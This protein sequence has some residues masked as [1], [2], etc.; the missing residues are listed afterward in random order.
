MALLEPLQEGEALTAAASKALEELV[1]KGR[2]LLQAKL[3][4]LPPLP[5]S[6]QVRQPLALS[7]LPSCC[8]NGPKSWVNGT[9]A[10]A[11]RSGTTGTGHG[12]TV[13]AHHAYMRSS[14]DSQA[15][16]CEVFQFPCVHLERQAV[17]AQAD[18]CC[19]PWRRSRT[20]WHRRG[21]T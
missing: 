12:A 14:S 7:P 11:E 21:A 6:I 19:R 13:T 15:K 18:A 16:V 4:G 10:A 2:H 5:Q 9:Q 17:K 3:K 1:I 20:S 8:H